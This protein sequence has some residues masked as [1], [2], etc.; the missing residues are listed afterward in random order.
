MLKKR[1]QMDS[2]KNS[3]KY[4]KDLIIFNNNGVLFPIPKWLHVEG[5]IKAHHIVQVD[6]MVR[7]YI[8]SIIKIKTTLH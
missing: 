3:W 8:K 2:I 1:V 6:N 4:E 5:N 7:F